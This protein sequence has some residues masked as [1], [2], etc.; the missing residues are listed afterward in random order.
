MIGDAVVGF[1]DCSGVAEVAAG[2]GLDSRFELAGLSD[3]VCTSN[4]V[5]FSAVSDLGCAVS[6]VELGSG[7]CTVALASC[8]NASTMGSGGSMGGTVDATF[9]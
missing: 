9:V 6:E 2:D 8:S 3:S 1:V 5:S 7:F 4:V